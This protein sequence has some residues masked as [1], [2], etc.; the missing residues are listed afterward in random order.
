MEPQQVDGSSKAKS[1]VK[2]TVQVVIL[3]ID[4][5]PQSVLLDVLLFVADDPRPVC[6]LGCANKSLQE[7]CRQLESSVLW[8]DLHKNRWKFDDGHYGTSQPTALTKEYY[9]HRYRRDLKTKD[10]LDHVVEKL[11]TKQG[12]NPDGGNDVVFSLRSL[13]LH[14]HQA[15]DV[16]WNNGFTTEPDSEGLTTSFNPS[17]KHALL[18]LFQRVAIL[19]EAAQLVEHLSLF[20]SDDKDYQWLEAFSIWLSLA[21]A[22][23]T[24]RDYRVP[25]REIRARIDGIAAKSNEQVTITSTARERIAVINRVFF[26]DEG[27]TGNIRDYYNVANSQLQCVLERKSA[28]PM[29]LAILYRCV[30]ER[31][32]VKVDIVGLPGHIVVGI[33]ALDYFMDVFRQGEVL[34]LEDLVAI[35]EQHFGIPFMMHF[36]QPSINTEV[37]KRICRNVLNTRIGHGVS[38]PI[39]VRALFDLL[40]KHGSSEIDNWRDGWYRALSREFEG[41]QAR[42][43][44]D[45]TL[46][47]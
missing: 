43:D 13:M 23:T 21:I 31:V 7:T 2:S 38:S 9:A 47:D 42:G 8:S 30:A 32:G 34:K 24:Y 29:T 27:F 36:V 44:V 16:C 37:L 20:P 22:D 18:L 6:R 3:M 11:Q 26:E 4:Q 10:Q 45:T 41:M 25:A 46:L 1:T 5:L 12:H 19:E 17:T 33:P 14:S 39:V 28:I 40:Q 15:L 35:V